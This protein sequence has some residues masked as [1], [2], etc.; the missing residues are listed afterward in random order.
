MIGFTPERT[1][2]LAVLLAIVCGAIL[3]AVGYYFFHSIG[4]TSDAVTAWSTLA[5]TVATAVLALFA[6]RTI[7]ANKTLTEHADLQASATVRLADASTEQMSF[8]RDQQIRER[9]D[10]FAAF[11]HETLV[12]TDHANDALLRCIVEQD[13]WTDSEDVKRVR[14]ELRRYSIQARVWSDYDASLS[15]KWGQLGLNLSRAGAAHSK[16]LHF[17]LTNNLERP[18]AAL[19][20]SQEV[21]RLVEL[22]TQVRSAAD[23]VVIRQSEQRVASVEEDLTEGPD[24]DSLSSS[25][26]VT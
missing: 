23:Q 11:L 15:L 25:A 16:Y 9:S 14:T 8:I 20:F 24:S 21:V 26:H 12:L 1:S 17:K 7:E 2:I 5:L 6:Y 19:A 13:L 10:R 18:S 4:L 3:G 22:V